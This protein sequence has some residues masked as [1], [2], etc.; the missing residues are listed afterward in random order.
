MGRVAENDDYLLGQTQTNRTFD[1]VWQ[2]PI[3]QSVIGDGENQQHP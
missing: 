2:G 3:Q 1:E